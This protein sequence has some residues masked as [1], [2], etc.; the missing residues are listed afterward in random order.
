[1][2]NELNLQELSINDLFNGEKCTFE[3]P[4]YQRNY[5]WEKEEIESLVN[6]VYD[7]FDKKS[8]VYYIGT[9]VSFRKEDNIFEV[10]DGQQRLTTIKILLIALKKLNKEIPAQNKLTYRA[11]KKSD[12][13][14]EFLSD[15]DNNIEPEEKDSGI[16]NGIKYATDALNNIEKVELDG[17]IKYFSENVHIIHYIVPRDIDLNHY[18]EVMNSRGEQL[19][20]HEII[21]ARLMEKLNDADK[22]V[23]NKIWVACSQMSVYIQDSLDF[24][25]EEIFSNELND[26]LPT[27]FESIHNATDETKNGPTVISEILNESSTGYPKEKEIPDSFQPIIDFPNFLLIVLKITRMSEDDFDLQN[28]KLDD[29]ELINEFKEK[30][31]IDSAWVKVFAFN[32]LKTKFLLDNYIVHHASEDETAESNPWLLQTYY[33][34]EKKYLKN[35]CKEDDIQ[36]KLV[37]LL[38]MFEVSF[39]AKQRKNYLFYCLYYLNTNDFKDTTLYAAFVENLADTYFDKVYLHQEL[40]NDINTPRPGTFDQ[41]IINGKELKVTSKPFEKSKTDFIAI[42]GDGK[43]KLAIYNN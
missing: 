30:N 8:K 12:K 36:D 4:I 24:K 34:G 27:N 23:F 6:D 2:A 17:F 39:T 13:T 40:L 31:N 33:K 11:R 38:S 35:L 22:L 42:Y 26:F 10:I 18:F 20:K 37:Q 7:G 1:M 9:L 21:K 3:I 14:L 19:E 41:M 5:A 43:T 29:K 28:F 16:V 15:P 25:A 32:L